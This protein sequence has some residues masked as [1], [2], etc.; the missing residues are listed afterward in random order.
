MPKEKPK[1]SLSQHPLW[2]LFLLTIGAGFIALAVQGIASH[3][4]FLTGGILGL[5]LLTW[6]NTNILSASIWNLLLNIPL[7]I[8]SWFRVSKRFVLYSAY[9][10]IAIVVWGSLLDFVHLPVENSLFAAILAGVLGGTGGG[11]MLRT[12]GSSGGLDLIGVYLNQ[13]WNIPI[14]RFLFA[15]NAALFSLSAFTISLDLVIVSFIQV[16]VSAS[17]VEYVLKLFNERKMVFIITKNGQAVCNGIIAAQGRA[18]LIP[19][20]GGYSHDA[21]EIVIT[22]TNNF[23]LKNLEELVFSIDPN[24]LFV[25]ENTFYVSGSQYPAKKK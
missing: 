6:Y 10:T 13:K 5:S 23:V 4:G 12:L 16:F 7:F 17:T 2:N 11:I 24:A 15:F 20:F 19:A 18:T 9:G 14:G 22:I 3:H 25:V 8:F 21:K 1:I